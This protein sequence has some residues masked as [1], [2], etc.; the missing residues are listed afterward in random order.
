MANNLIR[1]DYVQLKQI[2]DK[3]GR[4]SQQLAQMLQ[5][6][7]ASKQQLQDGDWVGQGAQAFYR[8]MDADV[9]PSLARLV[10]AMASAQRV[11]LALRDT[12]QQAERDAAAVLHDT[13]GN[14]ILS[15]SASTSVDSGAQAAA[16]VSNA[17]SSALGITASAL[18]SFGNVL[19][20]IALDTLL[21]QRYILRALTP[22][23]TRSNT[24][25]AMLMDM[26]AGKPGKGSWLLRFDGPHGGSPFPHLNLNPSLTGFKDP[27]TPLPAWVVE[28]AGK[29]A[30]VLEGVRRIALPVAVAIDAL[31]LG[32]AFVQ[33]GNTFGKNTI[34]TGGSVAGG[35]AGAWAGAEAG[36]AGGAFV[37]GILGSFVPVLGNAVGA[38]VGGFVGGLAGGIAGGLGGSW[39][40]G[41]ITSWF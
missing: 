9:L 2:A 36:A 34:R 10:K 39:L 37:G 15:L 38:G 31:R 22:D 13:S 8:E 40:G 1:T 25:V 32:D 16:G 18:A 3:F 19:K 17:A 11:T 24:T 27:H 5:T 6:M 20:G 41:K 14:A 33:D 29:T 28:G 21:P 30:R 4:E 35:W 26:L 7:R 23:L 12:I